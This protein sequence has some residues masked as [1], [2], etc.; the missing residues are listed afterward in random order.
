MD[1]LLKMI[2]LFLMAGLAG[3]SSLP[4][5]EY[6]WVATAPGDSYNIAA[7]WAD[8]SSATG[9]LPGTGDLMFVNSTANWMLVDADYSGA[10]PSSLYVGGNSG[11]HAGN[12]EVRQTGGT[13]SLDNTLGIGSSV[14]TG[15]Y[16]MT[17]GSLSSVNMYVGNGGTGTLNVTD[18]ALDASN[19]FQTGLSDATGTTTLDNSTLNTVWMAIGN[20]A[21]GTMYVQNGSSVTTGW[22]IYIGSDTG[23][24]GELVVTDSTFHMTAGD[25]CLANTNGS[26][27]HLTVEGTSTATFDG[28][29]NL[30][31]YPDA[32]GI[33]NKGYLVVKDSATAT[34][35]GNVNLGTFGAKGYVT[36][37]STSGTATLVLN[38][39]INVG[40]LSGGGNLGQ[41][42]VTVDDGGDVQVTGLNLGN[43]GVRPGTIAIGGMG[44]Q[45]VWNQDGGSTS[46]AQPVIVGEWDYSYWA[47]VGDGTLNLNGGTFLCPKITTRSTAGFATT[48]AVNFNGG[49]LKALASSANF[50]TDDG[51][52]STMTLKVQSGGAV[53]DSDVYDIEINL[54]LSE[55]GSDPGG[56]LTKWGSGSLALNNTETYTGTTSVQEGTLKGSGSIAGDVVAAAGAALA[57]GN[58]VGTLTVLGDASVAGDLEVEYDGDASTIDLLAVSG[59]LDLS[60]TLSF[61]GTGTLSGGPYV[62][63]TY[64]SLTAARPTEVNVPPGYTVDYAYGG[65]SVALVPEP[66]TLVLL[67]LGLIGLVAYARRR[68]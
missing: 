27:G 8:P 40:T 46:C 47:T 4:A 36:V 66:S 18:A 53:I 5:V 49:K 50:I 63:A 34:Y 3:V 28:G 21:S 42:T 51:N 38:A 35:S 43:D 10:N 25:L 41:G 52:G 45:G 68:K 24:Y 26:E 7:D 19:W 29:T 9:V 23:G 57:P 58:S 30:G 48:G 65:N 33:S 22:N 31:F 54:P 62:F 61:S 60:G 6:D 1:R 64:G 55:D 44:G 39:N 67:A 13:F 59:E 12:G 15:T 16:T 14:G 2:F 37:S 20:H 56:G 32:G 11:S 17:G